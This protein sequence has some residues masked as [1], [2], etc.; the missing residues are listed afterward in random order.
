M[1]PGYAWSLSLSGDT[2]ARALWVPEPAIPD[3]KIIRCDQ[4]GRVI[5]EDTQ[6][7]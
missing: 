6:V 1:D 4:L 5:Y 2:P 7:A 3:L